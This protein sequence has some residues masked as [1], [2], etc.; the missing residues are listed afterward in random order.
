MG[1]KITQLTGHLFAMLTNV[2]LCHWGKFTVTMIPLL[3]SAA[4]HI[5]KLLASSCINYK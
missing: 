1:G 5:R 4:D 3:C 2:K